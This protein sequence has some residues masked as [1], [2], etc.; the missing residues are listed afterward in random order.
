MITHNAVIMTVLFAVL[1]ST[2]AAHLIRQ[3]TA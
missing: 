3:L 1:A 2:E